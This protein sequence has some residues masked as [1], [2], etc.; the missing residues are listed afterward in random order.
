MK[1]NSLLKAFVF[2]QRGFIKY[3]KTFLY[4]IF[5]NVRLEGGMVRT[6][7]RFTALDLT[8]LIMYLITFYSIGRTGFVLKIQSRR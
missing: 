1:E 3:I 4:V 7:Y 2:I 5:L 8:V 6:R